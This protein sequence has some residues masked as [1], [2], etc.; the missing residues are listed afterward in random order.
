MKKQ[1]NFLFIVF[2]VA[3]FLAPIFLSASLVDAQTTSCSTAADCYKAGAKYCTCSGTEKPYCID[4]ESWS[5]N[6][7]HCSSGVNSADLTGKYC[8]KSSSTSS[9]PSQYTCDNGNSVWNNPT[10]VTCNDGKDDDYDGSTDCADSDCKGTSYCPTPTPTPATSYPACAQNA[11]VT[12]SCTCGPNVVASSGYC[13]SGSTGNYQSVSPCASPSTF[14]YCAINS[15]AYS[16]CICGSDSVS[17]TYGKYCCGSTSAS[18]W[19][20]TSACAS[21]YTPSPSPSCS[22]TNPWNCYNQADCT[23]PSVGG[24]WKTPTGGGSSYC[25]K[26]C[27]SADTTYCYTESACT[28]V[29]GKWCSN[30]NW[31]ASSSSSCPSTSP[32]TSPTPYFEPSSCSSPNIWNCKDKI[33]CESAGGQWSIPTSGGTGSCSQKCSSSNKY[34]CYD[35]ASCEIA[36]GQWSTSTYGGSGWCS[37]KCSSSNTWSCQSETECK[38]ATGVWCKSPSTNGGSCNSASYTC[39]TCSSSQIWNCYDSASCISAGGQ[40]TNPQY[41]GTGSCSQKCSSSNIWSCYTESDCSSASGKWCKSTGTTTSGSGGGYCSNSCPTCS[42]STTYNCYSETD[43]KG[44]SAN[45]CG[46]YCSSSAC[47]TCSKENYWNCNSESTCKGIAANWC[48]YQSSAA[49]SSIGGGGY[50]STSSCPTYSC[51][52][53]EMYNC[54]SETDCK[55]VGGLW[56]YNYCTQPQDKTGCTSAGLNWCGTYCTASQCPTCSSSQAWNCNDQSSC[57]GASGKWCGTYCSTSCPTCSSSQ[58]WNCNTESACTGA[59]GNWCKPSGTGTVP[60]SASYSSYANNPYCSSSSCPSCSPAQLWNCDSETKCKGASAN[61][62]QVNTGSYCS[63]SSC[64]TC[65]ST[66]PWNCYDKTSCTTTAGGDWCEHSYN[67]PLPYAAAGSSASVAPIISGYCSTKGTCPRSCP[68]VPPVICKIDEKSESKYD[69]N[70]CMVSQGCVKISNCPA[71][72]DPVCGSNGKTYPNSCEAKLAG[73]AYTTGSCST[74]SLCSFTAIEKDVVA[75]KTSGKGYTFDRDKSGCP[76]PGTVKCSDYATKC[77]TNLAGPEE[78]KKFCEQSGGVFQV[79]SDPLACSQYR[80]KYP[81]NV[82]QDCKTVKDPVT[83]LARTECP[84]RKAVCPPLPDKANLDVMEKKCKEYGGAFV[85]RSEYGCSFPDCTFG[86]DSIENDNLFSKSLASCPTNLDLERESRACKALNG[87]A[88]FSFKGDCK[89][90]KCAR[91]SQSDCTADA[92][93]EKEIQSKCESAGKVPVKKFNSNGCQYT[94]CASTADECDK[95]APADAAATCSAKGGE[96]IVKKSDNDC[97]EFAECVEHGVGSDQVTFEPAVSVPDVLKLLDIVLKLEELKVSFDSMAEKIADLA[98]YHSSVGNTADKEK[99]ETVGHM[100]QTAKDKVN[101]IEEKLKDKL[102]KI[103]VD[104]LN[105]VK[106]DLAVLKDGLLKE[107]LYSLLGKKG[108]TKTVEL[109]DCKND[110]ECFGQRLLTCAPTLYSP[111]V[112]AGKSSP[113]IKLEGLTTDGKCL[114]TASVTVDGKD[115][116]MKCELADFSLGVDKEKFLSSCKGTMV[117]LISN[118]Y[119][120]DAQPSQPS[121]S[122]ST[123]PLTGAVLSKGSSAPNSESLLTLE[124]FSYDDKGNGVYKLSVSDSDG[125]SSLSISKSNGDILTY[126]DSAA[127]SSEFK[128]PNTVTLSKPDFPLKATVKDCRNP[129]LTH[130]ITVQVPS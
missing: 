124:R 6:Y 53:S 25:T 28:G 9:N 120:E 99:F 1:A 26:K 48:S 36:G 76:V 101:E 78:S 50:C 40:W 54:K 13:C 69:T 63:S 106:K 43:C 129:T 17:Y 88:E 85:T 18:G 47:P 80:C 2:L 125:L 60:S 91:G 96:Y 79:D 32:N 74:V 37:D 104:E 105:D 72:Y 7:Y 87:K 46:T 94:T 84:T 66:Q 39:P 44:A 24:E 64:P 21:T 127:C 126:V 111:N 38:A 93:V 51:S 107:M 112:P 4:S 57:T 62:C 119:F 15:A 34:N 77:P 115:Y 95:D 103:T 22:S 118:N 58:Q 128:S 83:G 71:T 98:L 70:G 41:G 65:S 130:G 52:K 113:A 14:P 59:S 109:K 108:T 92:S 30:G 42:S 86:T 114:K 121:Q 75:C 10:E 97:V 56:S 90:V 117:D 3:G 49:S 20:S 45:W 116:S 35:K 73:A 11:Q 100:L 8:V 16:Q 110:S 33:T 27:S 23:S 81:T 102:E 19:W 55:G 122:A 29:G 61:W 12:T 82:F 123:A 67:N 31:C 5:V 68:Y 89:T